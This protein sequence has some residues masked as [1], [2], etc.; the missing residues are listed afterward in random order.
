MCAR[1]SAINLLAGLCV[2]ANA[3]LVA[4]GAGGTKSAAS[5]PKSFRCA[6]L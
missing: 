6:P 4:H 1:D 3:D 5:R 2:Q